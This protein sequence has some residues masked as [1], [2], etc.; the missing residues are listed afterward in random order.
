[1]CLHGATCTK[2][3][4][5][6]AHSAAE[7][8]GTAKSPQAPDALGSPSAAGS[9]GPCSPAALA[10]TK[11]L[12]TPPTR[13]SDDSSSRDPAEVL[14]ELHAA[15]GEGHFSLAVALAQVQL[16]Q[17]QLYGRALPGRV[18]PQPAAAA[19]R[20]PSVQEIL[21]A[22]LQQEQ[23][24]MAGLSALA[25]A[26]AQL[27]DHQSAAQL[28]SSLGASAVPAPFGA[29]AGG[30]LRSAPALSLSPA[31]LFLFNQQSLAQQAAALQVSSSYP[32]M[33]LTPQAPL[34]DLA[35][36]QQLQQSPL[37]V[38]AT[39]SPSGG[40]PADSASAFAMLSG[41]GFLPNA[42][43]HAPFSLNNTSATSSVSAPLAA[44]L[45]SSSRQSSFSGAAAVRISPRHCH[46]PLLWPIDLDCQT[47][48][49]AAGA[50]QPSL[51]TLGCGGASDQGLFTGG[52]CSS[53]GAS[54]LVGSLTEPSCCP[55]A[56]SSP[57]PTLATSP[58]QEHQQQV[59]L[60]QRLECLRR[61]QQLQALKLQVLQLHCQQEA[62]AAAAAAAAGY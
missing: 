4:C 5:F 31:S 6:F 14:V 61:E 46:D 10:S 26:Y 43:A 11:P 38:A 23:Q 55:V 22:A 45:S 13:D 56:F 25:A 50:R 20:V 37:D 34:L 36:L 17:R 32:G 40:N 47:G 54:S 62:A 2:P 60:Q 49:P 58:S 3:L 12:Q 15:R 35:A 53:S 33:N 39:L 48:G 57:A 27:D 19:V 42:H 44:P 18:Q 8:R 51:D 24:Q 1:M 52:A 59:L 21:G 16:R 30:M 41:L 7:L 29:A 9:S 28:L